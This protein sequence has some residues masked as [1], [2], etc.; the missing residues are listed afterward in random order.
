MSKVPCEHWILTPE[1]QISLS[2]ALR[3][4]IFEIQACP[5]SE[6]AKWPQNDLNHLS[7]KSTLCNWILTPEAQISLFRSTVARSPD[8]WGFW[9]NKKK[10]LK[11]G[12]SKFQKSKSVLLWGPL[13]RKFSKGWKAFKSDLREEWRF[14]GFWLP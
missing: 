11:I 12:N 3:P 6:C 9:G 14:E 5:K 10:S 4:A 13:R 8:N 2:F 1:V 7:V